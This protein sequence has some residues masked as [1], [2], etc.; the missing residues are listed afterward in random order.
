MS[1]AQGINK[2]IAY[3][4]QSGLGTA[5]SGT[6]GQLIRRETATFSTSKDA[7]SSNEIVSHQQHTGDTHG[8]RSTTATINGLLSPTTYK[9]FFASLLRK[10]WAATSD[11]TGLSVT[12]AAGS[13]SLFTITDGAA[14]FLTDGI[15]VGDVVRLSGGSLNSANAGVNLLVTAVTETVVTVL[16]FGVDAT[17]TAEGPIA[18]VTMSVP[19]QKTYVPT[20][21]HTNDY[22]TFEENWTD[23]TRYHLYQDVQIGSADINMPATGNIGINWSLVGLG[24]RTKSGTQ[25]LTTPSA[26]T[27]TGIAS[28]VAGK[29]LIGGTAYASVTSARVMIDGQIG[30]GEAVIG[31]NYRPD[32]QRGRIRVSGSF[33]A[34]YESDDLAASFDNETATSL[35]LVLADD[36]TTTADFITLSMSKVKLFSDDADD[37]EKQIVRTYSFV[38][39]INGEGGAALANNQTIISLQDSLI[40]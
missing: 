23:L 34:L 10:A 32:N 2:T 5:A 12:I 39:E 18:S 20:S 19:G 38:A 36:A 17:M 1:V 6:G 22:Y 25:T 16:P 8:V 33:T 31:S 14:T 3:K 27:T 37:G 30:A 11:I 13:G 7:Y 24:Y 35:V 40:A 15:K 9:D 4:K 29:V 26:E 21:G 28:S